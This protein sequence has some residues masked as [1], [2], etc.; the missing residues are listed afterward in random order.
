M[1]IRRAAKFLIFFGGS[2]ALGWFG[3][4]WLAIWILRTP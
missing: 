1:T 4:P 2:F 3:A